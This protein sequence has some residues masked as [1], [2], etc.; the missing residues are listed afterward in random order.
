[1][2]N[3]YKQMLYFSEMLFTIKK[4]KEVINQILVIHL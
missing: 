2:P 4:M 3:G 1:M